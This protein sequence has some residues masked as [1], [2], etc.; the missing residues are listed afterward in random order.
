MCAT[1]VSLDEPLVW[2][3]PH[4]SSTDRHHILGF[5]STTDIGQ[6]VGHADMENPFLAYREQLAV[7]AFGEAIGI[8]QSMRISIIKNLDSAIEHVAGVGFRRTPLVRA[9][10]LSQELGFSS[11]GGIWIKDETHNVAGSH[12]ARHLLTE[13][14]YLLMA[15]YAGRVPWSSPEHRPPLAIASC[16]NAAIAASTLARA[17]DWPIAVH[18]PVGTQD[19]VLSTL[20]ALHADVRTCPRIA[21]D[22][23]GDPCVFRFREI[24]R[25][26]AIPFG[27]QGTENVWC[28]DGGRTLGWEIADQAPSLNR[29][30]MQVGGGAF[31]ATLA[32]SFLPS[33]PSVRMHAVQTEGC[34]PLVRAWTRWSNDGFPD[35]VAQHWSRYMWPWE[36]EPISFADGILDDETYDWIEIFHGLKKSHGSAVMSSEVN[37][38]RAHELAHRHTQIDVSPTGSSGL[39]GVLEIRDQISDDEKVLV[40]FSGCTRA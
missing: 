17:V 29:V 22:P 34:A 16:G 10:E 3:C 7:D 20:S 13:L 39:A 26:G 23:A 30:F 25:D 2:T 35:D 31:A 37:I 1:H 33:S 38:V 24:V 14:V 6:H 28:L 27:V 40:V 18:V 4:S 9:E 32:Q 19:S 36:S 15:E 5:E 21:S 12:K 11:F 8:E